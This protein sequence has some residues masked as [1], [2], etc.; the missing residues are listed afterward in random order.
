M[1]KSVPIFEVEEHLIQSSNFSV[2]Q[3]KFIDEMLTE[4]LAPHFLGT[5]DVTVLANPHKN[6]HIETHGRHW[7]QKPRDTDINKWDEKQIAY[8]SQKVSCRYQAA[9]LVE[10][11]QLR[12]LRHWL[13]RSGL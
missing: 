11:L 4:Q 1:M 2:T 7:F 5:Y 12:D 13:M 8:G 6:C 3:V 10:F 9:S